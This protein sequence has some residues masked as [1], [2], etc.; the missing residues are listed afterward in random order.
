MGIIQYTSI[1]HSFSW[2]MD[3]HTYMITSSLSNHLYDT[4]RLL[5]TGALGSFP[6]VLGM[7]RTEKFISKLIE[8]AL[9]LRGR[10]ESDYCIKPGFWKKML[11]VTLEEY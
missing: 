10:G 2:Y 3:Q 9:V 11:L 5:C 8:I 1:R 7:T 6:S 4:D